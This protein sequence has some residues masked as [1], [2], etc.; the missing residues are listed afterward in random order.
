MLWTK[1][2]LYHLLKVPTEPYEHSILLPDA[3]FFYQTQ[4]SSTRRRILLPDAKFSNRH[5]ILLPDAGSSTDRSGRR[6]TL[7]VVLDV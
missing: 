2:N 1:C 5:R 3:E 6:I 4:N 7:P